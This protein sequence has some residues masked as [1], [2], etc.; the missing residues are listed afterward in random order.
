MTYENLISELDDLDI[1]FH[2]SNKIGR[3]KGLY[4]E[5]NI[6]I[7]TNI[8]KNAEKKCVLAEE[9]GHHYTTTGNILDQTDLNN[10]RQE[11][12]AREWGY[13][14]LV[15]PNKIIK[16]IQDGAQNLYEMANMLDITED[17]LNDALSYYIN[18]HGEYYKTDEYIIVFSPLSI[19]PYK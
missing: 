10:R 7:N 14:K 18:K 11:L 17:F 1:S 6:V 15:T 19:I 2:E 12:R 9:L 4:V 13:K 3:L 16:G 5:N 8:E